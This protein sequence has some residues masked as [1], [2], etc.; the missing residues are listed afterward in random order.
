MWIV[1][2]IHSASVPH[3]AS[4]R[5]I[6]CVYHLR[7][8]SYSTYQLHF[9]DANQP[10]WHC[11]SRNPI[12]VLNRFIIE[13]RRASSHAV[14]GLSTCCV[15]ARMALPRG[16]VQSNTEL[17]RWLHVGPNRQLPFADMLQ[18]V[19]RFLQPRT[20]S[21]HAVCSALTYPF[22]Q[23]Y[24]H[25]LHLETSN[26]R[27]MNFHTEAQASFIQWVR[28]NS[29]KVRFIY[30]TN[31]VAWVRERTIP[32]ERPPLVGQLSRI[33]GATWSAWLIPTAVF[34]DF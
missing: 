18:S 10:I 12:I 9:P 7:Y 13:I 4:I 27:T 25:A 24:V 22:K 15:S 32:T 20:E 30:K 21:F 26:G 17:C 5:R 8:L 29:H 14:R 33:E 28:F 16:P 6:R 11:V 23:S 31:S 2:N 1:G 34:S 19:E 3:R